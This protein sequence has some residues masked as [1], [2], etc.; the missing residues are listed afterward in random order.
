MNFRL[1]EGSS[2]PWEGILMLPFEFNLHILTKF[3]FLVKLVTDFYVYWRNNEAIK[4]LCRFLL[5]ELVF[6]HRGYKYPIIV[7]RNDEYRVHRAT[8]NKTTWFCKHRRGDGCKSRLYTSGKILKIYNLR[9]N[10]PPQYTEDE[11]QE[12][13]YTQQIVNVVVVDEDRSWTNKLRN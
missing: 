10:H 2:S 11:L 4:H 13:N 7:F 6:L 5:L 8:P 3:S 9:H 1:P 12:K